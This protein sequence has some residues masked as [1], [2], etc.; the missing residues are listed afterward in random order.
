MGG[1]WQAYK[2]NNTID[3]RPYDQVIE[4]YTSAHLVLIDALRT[5]DTLATPSITHTYI[6]KPRT[7]STPRINQGRGI[8]HLRIETTR[9]SDTIS[10]LRSK[11]NTND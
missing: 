8:R 6:S 4:Y 2:R 7:V 1:F 10:Q 5:S 11:S 3:V 9:R